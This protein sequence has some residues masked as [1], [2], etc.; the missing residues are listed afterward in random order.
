MQ[1][2]AVLC[3]GVFGTWNLLALADSTTRVWNFFFFGGCM[4]AVQYILVLRKNP[5]LRKSDVP[6]ESSKTTQLN[7]FFFFYHQFGNFP[8]RGIEQA[9]SAC[10]V[11][12]LR[13]R[14][15]VARRK[16]WLFSRR[17][18]L[19]LIC[20]STLQNIWTSLIIDSR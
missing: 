14:T 6:V 4:R 19:P 13:G 5:P 7:L 8:S 18:T 1:R 12:F 2:V 9:Q 11:A 3:S 10:L 15:R 17:R 20:S 16:Y